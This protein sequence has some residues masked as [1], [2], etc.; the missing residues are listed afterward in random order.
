MC[1]SYSSQV[2]SAKGTPR[3]GRPLLVVCG[4]VCRTRT[5]ALSETRTRNRSC[6]IAQFIPFNAQPEILY[7]AVQTL[8]RHRYKHKASPYSSS[9][10]ASTHSRPRSA[11]YACTTQAYASG[12]GWFSPASGA[13]LS[14][15][16]S[17]LF[18]LIAGKGNGQ[19]RWSCA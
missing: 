4:R 5:C 19:G 11:K 8:R 17:A 10:S 18:L 12:L 1:A 9:S 7:K 15:F 14:A 2:R 3:P 16:V 6:T 13:A